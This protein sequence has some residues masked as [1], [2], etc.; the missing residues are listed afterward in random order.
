[1]GC[2]LHTTL[3]GPDRICQESSGFGLQDTDYPEML[4]KGYLA[5]TSCYTSLAHTSN[6]LEPYLDVLDQVFALIAGRAFSGG[7]PG[8]SCLPR[9]LQTPELKG[10]AELWLWLQ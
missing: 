5:A 2:S 7:A 9:W 8:G 10:C 1:M 4:K 3:T 6:V